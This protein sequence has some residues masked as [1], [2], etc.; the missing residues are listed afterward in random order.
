[1]RHG[2]LFD[3]AAW[4]EEASRLEGERESP[5]FWK[6]S[7][8]AA[9]VNRLLKALYARIEQWERTRAASDELVDLWQLFGDDGD[10]QQVEDEYRRV[11]DDYEQLRLDAL[12]SGEYD[13][14]DCYLA[15]QS[16]AGGTESCDWVQML[17]RMYMRWCE[18][19]K[20][21]LKIL[22]I[23]EA[24]GGLKS[25]TVEISGEYA[26]GYLRGEHGIHRLV[27]I[28]PFDSARRR[29]TT[30]AAVEI[31]PHIVTSIAMD[32]KSE[33]IRIDT[34]RA[35]GAGG[36]HV[37]KTD[38]AVRITHVPTGIV[39]QCQNERSQHHNKET[40]ME[41]LRSRLFRRYQVEERERQRSLRGENRDISWGNQI[42][43]YT[44][45]PYTLVKDHRFDCEQG[46][47]QA[48]M[49]GGIDVFIHGYLHAHLA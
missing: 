45:H 14:A 42:R 18:R 4:R 13:H 19:K 11:C 3:H 31:S 48:V 17:L 29:H 49:D 5:N 28:S 8:R 39:A 32:I 7:Q 24:E 33:D 25:V 35:S 23:Q 34:Y 47:I 16:G 46:N 26:F 43:S 27:R 10:W 44:F 1:M 20:F 15:I 41:I 22:D 12:L 37:N 38:S 21:A 9:E 30:F 6:D 2:G 40:A 36:Q